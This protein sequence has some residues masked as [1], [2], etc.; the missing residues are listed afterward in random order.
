MLS[1]LLDQNFNQIILRG[2]RARVQGLDA[3]T[4]YEVGLSAVSDAE[5]L[6]WADREGRLLITHDH[7]TMPDQVAERI[8]AGERTSGVLLVSRKLPIGQVIDEL[9][10]IVLCSQKPDWENMLRHLPL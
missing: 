7:H 2:L 8:A 9:E 6:A 5:L 4:A 1:L 3:I 10:I